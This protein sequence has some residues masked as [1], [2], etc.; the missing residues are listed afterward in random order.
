MAERMV[1]IICT[2]KCETLENNTLRIV[3]ES[4]VKIEIDIL[5]NNK[6]NNCIAI[7]I[8]FKLKPHYLGYR[9][10]SMWTITSRYFGFIDGLKLDFKMKTFLMDCGEWPAEFKCF[11]L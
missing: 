8:D 7:R 2:L 1:H 9:E 4:Q 10:N 5:K 11:K 3:I 6:T